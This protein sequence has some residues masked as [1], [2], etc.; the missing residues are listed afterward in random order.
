MS[1]TDTRIEVS[2]EGTA[3]LWHI[4]EE[5]NTYPNKLCAE[6]AARIAFPHETEEQRYA[7]IYFVRYHNLEI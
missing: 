2:R 5:G 3:Y 6:A 4:R 1:P 7:R